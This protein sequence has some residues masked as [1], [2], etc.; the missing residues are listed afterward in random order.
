MTTPMLVKRPD[1][2]RACQPIRQTRAPKPLQLVTRAE[3]VGTALAQVGAAST[4]TNGH[5][6]P[7][8]LQG[9]TAVPIIPAGKRPVGL[10]LRRAGRARAPLF[11]GAPPGP[12]GPGRGCAAGQGADAAAWRRKGGTPH[13]PGERRDVQQ[14]GN[15]RMSVKTLIREAADDESRQAHRRPDRELHD[16]QRLV[17][18]QRRSSR[19]V[20][21]T[22]PKCC[23]AGR[24]TGIRRSNGRRKGVSQVSPI[25]DRQ[26]PPRSPAGGDDGG[27]NTRKD[28]SELVA[29]GAGTG[30]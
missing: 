2:R 19:R 21:Q 16:G 4:R 26:V 3:P 10:W 9:V 20:Q 24:T 1:A 14:V 27:I 29:G 5:Q 17:A 30:R 13:C 6:R 7:G 18:E 25:P 22:R 8:P 23:I 15:M 28:A 11:G 12:S